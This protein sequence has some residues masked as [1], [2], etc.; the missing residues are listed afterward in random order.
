MLMNKALDLGKAASGKMKFWSKYY[1]PIHTTFVFLLCTIIEF[2]A[3]SEFKYDAS[4]II[5][6]STNTTQWFDFFSCQ[7]IHVDVYHLL[8]NIFVILLLGGILELI[9][10]PI[11]SFA[12]FWIGGT[13]GMMLEAGWWSH[14]RTR[15]LGASSGAYALCAAY[16]SHLIMNW[17]ETPF[18]LAWFTSFILCV[19]LTILF[20][21]YTESVRY[22]I[23]HLAHIGGTLQGLFVG[24]LVV[25]NVKVLSVENVLKYICFI[26]AATFILS[27]WYRISLVHS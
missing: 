1:F 23:A 3:S 18:R 7:L 4:L 27:V 19:I 20:Y 25:R 24:C 13:T 17:K 9:H 14:S 2:G 15:L 5:P 22:N 6:I 11:P 10:G 8:N 21:C 16:L 12:I 26:L